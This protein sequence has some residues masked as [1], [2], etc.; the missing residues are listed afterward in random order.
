MGGSGGVGGGN[1][2]PTHSPPAPRVAYKCYLRRVSSSLTSISLRYYS[3]VSDVGLRLLAPDVRVFISKDRRLNLPCATFTPLLFTCPAHASRATSI[4]RDH[5]THHPPTPQPQAPHTSGKPA[6][7]DMYALYR[8]P[9]SLSTA[10]YALYRIRI[11]G[12]PEI[13]VL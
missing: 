1:D 10:M 12:Y 7:T 9:I 2:D 3:Q 5:A 6:V 4:R 13:C 8:I 11:I